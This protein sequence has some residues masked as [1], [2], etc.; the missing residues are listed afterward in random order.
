MRLKHNKK[1]NTAFVYEALVRELTKS[2]VKNNKAKVN[3]I[4]PIMKTFFNNDSVL[5]RELDLYRSLYETR[6]MDKKTAERVLFESRIQYDTFDKREIFKTQSDLINQ[7]NKSV[8]PSVFRN[9]VPNYKNIASV[10]SI[11]NADITA[12]D[13]V[14]LENRM[15][16]EMT[17]SATTQEDLPEIDDLV[18]ETF[19]RKFNEKY[20]EF[21]LSEQRELLNKYISSF[22]DGG[23]EFRVYLNEEISRLKTALN[24][25]AKVE[26][27]KSD[28]A[29][30]ENSQKIGDLLNSFS[31][32]EINDEMIEDVLKIQKLTAEIISNEA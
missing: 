7:I 20:S 5:R 8:S 24:E 11:F 2:I 26:E 6:G 17:A 30:L 23:L 18:Y 4:V 3:K 22:V 14:L 16:S 12:K 13:R 32:I 15:V 10:H 1:R 25:A 9:F 27:V 31:E 28:S 29:L 21:L 19:V